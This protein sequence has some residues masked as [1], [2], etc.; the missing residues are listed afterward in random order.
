MKTSVLGLFLAAAFA[1]SAPAQT[2]PPAAVPLW[3]VEWAY[4]SHYHDANLLL[5]PPAPGEKRVVFY[6]DSITEAWGNL[7]RYFPGKP[8]VNR[9]TS[10]QTTNQMLV[11]FRQDVLRLKPAAVVILAGTNDIAGNGGPITLEA[12]EDNL[13]SM[14]ELARANGIRVILSSVLPVY[15]YP[16]RPGL[17]PAKKIVS[18]NRWIADYSVRNN[19]VYLDYYRLMVDGRGGLPPSLAKDGVHPTPA[20]YAI[21]APLAERA[22]EETLSS[23]ATADPGCN[24]AP[25]P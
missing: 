3:K 15:D 10:G 6:G 11:R 21:M 14:A 20:G 24:R 1:S 5:G 19:L 9:G 8:Y 17:Q 25:A 22:I 18:L 12:T 2:A 7:D 23:S 13:Q 4:L 16:W